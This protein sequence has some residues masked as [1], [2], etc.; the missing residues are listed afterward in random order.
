MEDKSPAHVLSELLCTSEVVDLTFTIA[1]D[2]PAAWPSNMPFQIRVWNWFKQIDAP[3]HH[4]PS[5]IPFQTR[6]MIL[7][8]HVGTH[9]DAPPHFIPPAATGLPLASEL[10][11]QYA[12][13]V[14]LSR[15]CGPA[16]VIDVR[17]LDGQAPLGASPIIEP[18]PIRA[19]E[20]EHG[21]LK[22]GEIVLFYTGWDRFYLPFPEGN[23]YSREVIAAQRVGW[24]SPDVGAAEYLLGKGVTVFGSDGGSIGPAH[25][26]IPVHHFA[27]GHGMLLVES[28]TNLGKLPPRGAFFMFLPIKVKYG[29]G[30]PGR[31][32]AIVPR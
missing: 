23:A 1:E 16:A 10:G 9:F 19:W 12:D 20:R 26:G 4:V 25:N 21:A 24:P 6:W 3:L 5:V 28:L 15:L 18:E 11:N 31:A 8:E 29:S 2:V 17:Y 30:A 7:D 32:I 27:L 22:Q 13:L 14:P